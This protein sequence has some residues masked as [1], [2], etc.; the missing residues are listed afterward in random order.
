M[1]GSLSSVFLYSIVTDS[2]NATTITT[3]IIATLL[4]G[5]ES[6]PGTTGAPAA[7]ATTTTEEEE[8]IKA[9][10][11]LFVIVSIFFCFVDRIENKTRKFPLRRKLKSKTLND[12]F[13]DII[14][15]RFELTI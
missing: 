5:R 1:N 15:E 8:E 4:H 7:A 2:Y 11:L 9:A 12:P 3:I 14:N 6:S 10:S 13:K